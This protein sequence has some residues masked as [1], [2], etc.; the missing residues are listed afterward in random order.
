VS[1]GGG[2]LTRVMESTL[3]GPRIG[4]QLDSAGR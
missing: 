4:S 1:E 3:S 2:G